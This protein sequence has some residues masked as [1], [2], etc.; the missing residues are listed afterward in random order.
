MS[1]LWE[2]KKKSNFEDQSSV[3]IQMSI[4]CKH[5]YQRL[6]F[7]FPVLGAQ[8]AQ[9]IPKKRNRE[10]WKKRKKEYKCNKTL[11][12]L[13]SYS[14]NHLRIPQ[15]S[16]GLDLKVWNHRSTHCHIHV[17]YPAHWWMHFQNSIFEWGL[18]SPEGTI[19]YVNLCSEVN[20]KRFSWRSLW[21]GSNLQKVPL[22]PLNP[23]L[24]RQRDFLFS[25]RTWISL[26]THSN[27]E[28]SRS[29]LV[30]FWLFSKRVG[31]RRRGDSGRPGMR[32]FVWCECVFCVIALSG[33]V[34]MLAR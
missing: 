23:Y 27:T 10:K 33:W 14:I 7:S 8:R 1:I 34:P 25:S 13:L 20:G 18:Y 28:A 2:Q 21:S 32:Q 31:E 11:S 19:L 17:Q 30:T 15:N 12:F 24:S 22:H 3:P 4:I 9:L 5:Q 29:K 16:L 6:N 26:R